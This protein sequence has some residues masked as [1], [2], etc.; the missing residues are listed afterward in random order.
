MCVHTEVCMGW[1]D[2][3]GTEVG[4]KL[5]HRIYFN[6]LLLNHVNVFHIDIL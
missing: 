4:K 1:G 5:L 2:E 3:A 6:F